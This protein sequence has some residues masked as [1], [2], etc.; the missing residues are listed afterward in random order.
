M[1]NL[2]TYEQE[3]IKKETKTQIIERLERARAEANKYKWLCEISGRYNIVIYKNKKKVQELK[4]TWKDNPHGASFEEI[5][6][7]EHSLMKSYQDYESLIESE[8]I[9]FDDWDERENKYVNF[10]K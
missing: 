10:N 9:L 1:S 6:D 3:Q 4:F 8:I 7:L 5:K 2:T